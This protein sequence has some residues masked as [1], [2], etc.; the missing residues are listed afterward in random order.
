MSVRHFTS[1]A[2]LSASELGML[3]DLALRLKHDRRPANAPLRGR[4]LAQIFEKP[5]LRTRLSFDVGMAEL[6]G[7][8]VYLSPQEV[9]LGRRESVA[10]VARVISRMVD[11]VVL[12]TNAHETIE[13]FA[14]YSSVPVING[15]SDLS[16]P[17]QGLADI[18]TIVEKKGPDLRDVTVAYVG[19][20]NNVLHSLMLAAALRSARIRI[21]TPAG[22][23]P[24]RRYVDIAERIVRESGA[25]LDLGHDPIESVRD[26]DVVYTDVWTSMGQEQEYERRRRAFQGYQVNSEL[27]RKAK[28]DAI[29]MHD[30]P[31]H[32]G[33]EITDEVMDGPQSVVF[34]QAE[35]RLHAQKALLC[36]LMGKAS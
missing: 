28:P 6:G 23:E 20:G 12:R 2:E 25:S 29:V 19:D 4:T 32:R 36:W 7:Q 17:C 34:D 22:F 26:A 18:L 8:C 11:A 31:A 24:D 14:R 9:G 27:L 10:D 30:L 15:L 13:E 1:V 21:A 33:E 5:S 16:H 35:N 3:L